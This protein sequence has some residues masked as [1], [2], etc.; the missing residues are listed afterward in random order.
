[1]DST[2]LIIH[3]R[4]RTIRRLR[5]LL[6]GS[7][8][9]VEAVRDAAGAVQSLRRRR[10]DLALVGAGLPKGG[11]VDACQRIRNCTRNAPVPLMLLS[12]GNGGD[13]EPSLAGVDRVPI[14]NRDLLATVRSKLHVAAPASE[15][16]TIS[17]DVSR[18][19]VG[20]SGDLAHF[21]VAEMV[22]TLNLG[23][24]TACVSMSRGDRRG[25]I[26]FDEG[27]V[28]HAGTGELGGEN[29]F[30]E[31]MRW[32]DGEFRIGYGE[33]TEA[34]TIDK[35]TMYLVMEALRRIDEERAQEA[36]RR[37]AFAPESDLDRRAGSE[38]PRNVEPVPSSH[39]V[40]APE[41]TPA[42][43]EPPNGSLTPPLLSPHLREEVA[44]VVAAVSKPVPAESRR[45]APPP[46]YPADE[47]S[48]GGAGWRWAALA[49]AL[50]LVAFT[51]YG[52]LTRLSGAAEAGADATRP[53]P[54]VERLS[55]P[56]SNASSGASATTPVARVTYVEPRRAAPPA[57]PSL[58]GDGEPSVPNDTPA[59]G[60]ADDS[61]AP[62][63]P[64]GPAGQPPATEAAPRAEEL[65]APPSEPAPE[66]AAATSP[67]APTPAQSAAPV[68]PIGS[69][70]LGASIA[71][72]NEIL[73]AM[74]EPGR[75]HLA[76]DS[77]VREGRIVLSVDGQ[78]VFSRELAAERK[79]FKKPHEAFAA[80][81]HLEP[82]EHLLAIRL[83]VAGE[84]PHV[85]E[86]ALE[87]EPGATRTISLVTGKSRKRP[88][89]LLDTDDAGANR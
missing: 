47:G 62:A 5:T 56:V 35:D 36:S 25:S 45:P 31:L 88:I 14:G 80:A 68:E 16:L 3:N 13:D 40:Q 34:H 51:G 28:R 49:A 86:V 77:H 83:D 52:A 30:F 72:A 55:S 50:G 54:Q 44:Q 70:D 73:A 32:T 11:T 8:F 75:L 67:P 58:D 18:G 38:P 85:S 46:R 53:S 29:A 21:S 23:N 76:F 1:M 57:D 27:V 74:P 61:T 78:Q 89:L 71:A 63:E 24:K 4:D 43:V 48:T 12:S 65:D 87:I 20:V 26:W 59:D 19:A 82:G 41:G 9:R 79:G 42:A 6:E 10:P 64:T 37:G 69:Q 7:G 66:P 60:P 39:V 84:E 2:I 81:L 22:Q 15:A 33:R 17:E